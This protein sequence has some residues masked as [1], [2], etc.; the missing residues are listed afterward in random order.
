[1]HYQRNTTMWGLGNCGIPQVLA[2]LLC[3]QTLATA[4][5][6]YNYNTGGKRYP[7]QGWP[8]GSLFNLSAA[9]NEESLAEIVEN[10]EQAHTGQHGKIVLERDRQSLQKSGDQRSG[11]AIGSKVT[12]YDIQYE[13]GNGL[14]GSSAAPKCEVPIQKIT[15]HTADDVIGGRGDPVAQVKKVIE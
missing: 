6:A 7:L 10:D 1:M 15:D 2:A 14:S 3:S 4:V 11:Q 8:G 9:E 13:A 5:D 12:D